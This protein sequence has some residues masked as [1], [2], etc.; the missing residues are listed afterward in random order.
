V[1]G[2]LLLILAVI[3]STILWP[4]GR[5]GLQGDGRAT[6]MGF[7]ISL[8][9]GTVSLIGWLTRG[10]LHVPRGV[11]MAA[12]LLGIAYAIGFCML[13]M[14]CLKIGPAGPTVTINNLAMV[15]GVLY[16]VM[17]L[18]PMGTPDWRV[19][20]GS[21]HSPEH[22]CLLDRSMVAAPLAPRVRDVRSAAE[23]DVLADRHPGR[24]QRDLRHHRDPARD[25]APPE[26]PDRLAVEHHRPLVVDKAGDRPQQRRLPGAVRP[27]QR[28]PL[29]V[30]DRERDAV[31]DVPA[32]ELDRQTLDRE[33]THVAILRDV[34]ST[35]AKN[36]APKNA[37]T[38]PIGS[39]PGE[40]AVRAITSARTRNPAPTSTES[41]SSNR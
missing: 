4:V 40:S 36:G 39:S 21:G 14:Q 9:M 35:T 24:H 16:D 26:A 29:A 3:G 2:W 32:P 8:T 6:V 23:E 33:R 41:G 13:I 38:T 17:Y 7:W 22:A 28:H 19:I 20:V 30:V 11:C 37:V 5:W 27:D 1:S 25:L 34:R 18:R 15:C 31:D 10:G 12:A